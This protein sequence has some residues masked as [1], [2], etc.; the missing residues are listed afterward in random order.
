MDSGLSFADSDRTMT[1]FGYDVW[2]LKWWYSCNKIVL[3]V[4]VN[5]CTHWN[6]YYGCNVCLSLYNLLFICIT[7]G[8]RYWSNKVCLIFFQYILPA[9]VHINSQPRLLRGD[10]PI[11]LVLAPTRELAQQIQQVAGDFGAS[12]HVRNTCVFGGAPK[13]PQVMCG[14]CRRCNA[15]TSNGGGILT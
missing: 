3:K 14:R 7:Y 2:S 10:G 9:I 4:L 5:W 15:T 6:A 8:G 1:E 13:G 11:A 12:S